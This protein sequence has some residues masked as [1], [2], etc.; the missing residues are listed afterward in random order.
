MMLPMSR[1]LVSFALAASLCLAQSQDPPPVVSP[2]IHWNNSATLRIRA[3]QAHEVIVTGA[4]LSEKTPMEKG[5]DGV[6]TLTTPGLGGGIYDYRFLVDGV[7]TLDPVNPR[8]KHW[9]GGSSSYFSVDGIGPQPWDLR[10]VPHGTVHIEYYLSSATNSMRSYRV[11]TPPGYGKQ[12]RRYPVLYLLH[13]SGDSEREWTDFGRAHLI[14]DNL[15]DE[16]KIE[17]MV[18]VMPYGHLEYPPNRGPNRNPHATDI[19]VRDI[20]EG[21]IP[22]VEGKYR[23]LIDQRSRA[24]AGLSMGGGQTL[25]LATRRPDLFAWAGVFS[26]GLRNPEQSVPDLLADPQRYKKLWKL[27]WIACGKED[28][29]FQRAGDLDALLTKLDIDHQFVPT[30][31]GHSWPNWRDYLTRFTPLLFRQ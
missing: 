24:V 9:A 1:L 10:N 12:E 16:G 30:S 7:P 2:E 27:F 23:V 14:L 15:Y 6:W 3:P 13:G 5:E 31:G 18:V 8:T 26:A 4:G 20:I 25:A 11:Y 19:I 29:G 17:P 28:P 22:D 21:V